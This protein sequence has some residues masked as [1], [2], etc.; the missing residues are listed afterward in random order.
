M[1]LDR[2]VK[3]LDLQGGLMTAVKNSRQFVFIISDT[4]FDSKYCMDEV[5]QAISSKIPIVAIVYQGRFKEK[6]FPSPGDY[7]ADIQAAFQQKAIDHSRSYFDTFI[8]QLKE[9][10]GEPA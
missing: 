10:L 1:F 6:T 4:I 9:R 5:R 8:A 2:E 3:G 7:P